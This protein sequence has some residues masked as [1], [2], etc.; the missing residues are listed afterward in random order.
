MILRELSSTMS[1]GSMDF[2][3]RSCTEARL[4]SRICARSSPRLYGPGDADRAIG[5]ALGHAVDRGS[6][7]SGDWL[8]P[9]VLSP[10]LLAQFVGRVSG[11]H[12]RG[13]AHRRRGPDTVV[14]QGE[15]VCAVPVPRQ[16]RQVVLVLSRMHRLPPNADPGR[17]GP[18]PP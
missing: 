13:L 10:H 3:P 18:L 8:T 9:G 15:G 2:G 4:S 7:T 6:R 17:A 12:G 14:A 11:K 16:A 5:V 1:E